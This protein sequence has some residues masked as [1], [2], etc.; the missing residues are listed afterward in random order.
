MP[1]RLT[2]ILIDDNADDLFLTERGIHAAGCEHTVKSFED[3]LEALALLEDAETRAAIGL[4]LCDV[5]MPLMNGFDVLQKIRELKLTIPFY[6]LSSSELE[7]DK[8]RAAELGATGYL[9]KMPTPEALA[10][11]IAAACG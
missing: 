11:I 5:R 10:K 9:V 6:L 1:S 2:I 3:P 7:E 8:N 4:I